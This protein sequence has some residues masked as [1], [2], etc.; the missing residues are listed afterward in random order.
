M[1]QPATNNC[2]SCSAPGAKLYDE[3]REVYVCSTVCLA[4]NI[5]QHSDEFAEWYAGL[6]VT[7]DD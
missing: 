2:A 3:R 4:D 1:R 7:E 6:Y 5:A